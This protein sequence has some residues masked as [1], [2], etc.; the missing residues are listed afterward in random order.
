M[1]N[2]QKKSVYDRNYPKTDRLL[3]I[4]EDTV[5]SVMQSNAPNLFPCKHV[6]DVFSAK[7]FCDNSDFTSHGLEWSM[8]TY[9]T[10]V[11]DGVRA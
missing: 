11:S 10:L 9:D 6:Y 7:V 3:L 2:D 4:D 5:N 8:L 1:F